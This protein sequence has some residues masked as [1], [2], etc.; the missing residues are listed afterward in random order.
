MS[1]H[2]PLNFEQFT[3]EQKEHIRK[4]INDCKKGVSLQYNIITVV[5]DEN[6]HI[7]CVYCFSSANN[8]HY[9][10]QIYTKIDEYS[11]ENQIAKHYGLL[12]KF[13]D[14][15]SSLSYHN[16]QYFQIGKAT[17][18]IYMKTVKDASMI[19]DLLNEMPGSNWD[20]CHWLPL[21]LN[22][23]ESGM[24]FISKNDKNE[25]TGRQYII[26]NT[27]KKIGER[28]SSCVSKSHRNKGIMKILDT[29]VISYMN[30]RY[31]EFKGIWTCTSLK[32]YTSNSDNILKSVNRHINSG[33]C[34]DLS[35]DDTTPLGNKENFKFLSIYWRPEPN[36]VT[37]Y[38]KNAASIKSRKLIEQYKVSIY[39]PH[40]ILKELRNIRTNNENIEIGGYLERTGSN[41]DLIIKKFV[42]PVPNVTENEKT[43]GVC[44]THYFTDWSILSFHTHPDK[45]YTTND[46][47]VAWPSHND[48]QLLFNKLFGSQMIENHFFA[49]HFV[50]SR[51]GMYCMTLSK[52]IKFM[53]TQQ[54]FYKDEIIQRG[55]E[56]M[57]TFQAMIIDSYKARKLEQNNSHNRTMAITTHLNMINNYKLHGTTTN[58]FELTFLPWDNLENT[59]VYRL[60]Y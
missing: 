27:E 41:H 16:G 51:E 25:I 30:V 5:A 31:P 20:D 55:K 57:K 39:I 18:R 7:I 14:G 48:W 13:K 53:L 45:C 37:Q 54:E 22:K 10:V 40:S 29:N 9:N 52:E 11:L 17:D 49:G 6:N 19:S 4:F 50:I 44:R 33:Y 23:F 36:Q 24:F 34:W 32:N 1:I 12:Q 15:V 60:I 28:Y 38:V 26:Y 35:I 3:N 59:A 42:K 46:A 56:T 47:H 58:L 43:D 2:G 8:K 21:T